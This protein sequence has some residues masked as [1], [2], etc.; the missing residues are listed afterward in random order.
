MWILK[1]FVILYK[2]AYNNMSL[3]DQFL[4]HLLLG[5]IVSLIAL[6]ALMTIV[7]VVN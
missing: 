1:N 2:G 4:L 3:A 5:T 7:M 6:A